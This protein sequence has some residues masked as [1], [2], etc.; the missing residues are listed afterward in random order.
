[1]RGFSVWPAMQD[2]SHRWSGSRN[3]PIYHTFMPGVLYWLPH[4]CDTD[5]AQHQG[6]V[7]FY[8]AS[9]TGMWCTQR[10]HMV[11]GDTAVISTFVCADCMFLPRLFNLNTN[12]VETFSL[13]WI[14]MNEWQKRVYSVPRSQPNACWDIFNNLHPDKDERNSLTFWE[15]KISRWKDQYHSNSC[16][17]TT[18]LN[19]A[20]D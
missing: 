17:L 15:N 6:C 11:I 8:W 10:V 20:A 9:H 16:T 2:L 13:P 1:M 3:Q 4:P 12:Q 5:T 7:V 18:K 19:V 14:W